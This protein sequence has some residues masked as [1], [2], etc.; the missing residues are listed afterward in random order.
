MIN[1]LLKRIISALAI[2]LCAVFAFLP[3]F[4]AEAAGVSVLDT[5]AMFTARD[6]DQQPKSENVRV[7]R[8]SHGQSL[9]ITEEG[10][11]VIRGQAS[12][13]TITVEASDEAKIQLVLDGV[14]ITN[15]DFPCIYVKSAD[16]VFVTTSADSSLT[17]T[18][19]FRSDGET[20]TNAVIFSR[21]DLVLNGTASLTISSSY[22]GVVSKDDLKITGG[23][24]FI[25]AARHAVKANDSIR[26][27]GG[28]LTLNA[29]EDG[30]HAE[31]DEDPEKGYIYIAGGQFDI[32]VKDDAIHAE[33]VL[34]I[35]KGDFQISGSEGLEGTYIQINGGTIHI[36]S[37]DD[38]I[39]AGQKSSAYRA[40]VEINGGDITIVM[41]AGDTDGVDSNGDLFING[42]TINVTGNS[43]F[44]YDGSATFNG[45]TIIVNGQQLN[46]IPNQMMGGRGGTGFG[47]KRRQ[48]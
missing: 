43:G 37:S 12:E 41:G 9:S 24:Y 36:Q 18:G 47:G 45:G 11:Y 22:H 38:G 30:L 35:D 32:T 28:N 17:V 46:S 13:A 8:I 16:K 4:S 23:K 6:M 19:S 42:G 3:V 25:T 27:A 10:V 14:H 15:S 31:N 21:S 29:G 20:K 5:D 26:I 39:N 33:S 40:T 34:Q 48:W 1:N 44:D 7:L 2:G